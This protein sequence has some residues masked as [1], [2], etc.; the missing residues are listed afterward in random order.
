MHKKFGVFIVMI[1]SFFLI[2]CDE[3]KNEEYHGARYMI[4]CQNLGSD[5]RT[6]YYVDDYTFKNNI[7]DFKYFDNK[8]ERKISVSKINGAC[9]IRPY[10]EN[11]LEAE[12]AEYQSL[13]GD[14]EINY[15]IE[16]QKTNNRLSDKFYV[17]KYI[18]NGVELAFVDLSDKKIYK[19]IN[20]R[21]N[22]SNT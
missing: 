16:C 11:L 22:V 19:F 1:F 7:L 2:G 15:V 6:R 14:K 3:S 4:S 21:C 10:M 8:E 12:K 5:S 20:G 9:L 18:Y 13:M 17:N